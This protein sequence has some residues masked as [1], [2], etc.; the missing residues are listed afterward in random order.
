MKLSKKLFLSL[1]IGLPCIL[2]AILWAFVHIK[3]NQIELPQYNLIYAVKNYGP[4]KLTVTNNALYMTI[5]QQTVSHEVISPQ[6]FFYNVK[7]HKTTEIKYQKPNVDLKNR[8]QN[9]DIRVFSFKDYNINTNTLAPDGY[10]YTYGSSH[11]PLLLFNRYDYKIQLIKN[12]KKIDLIT[13]KEH[14][15]I[16]ILGWLIPENHH[17]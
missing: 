7:Y 10:R 9:K 1:G 16:K 3:Q 5:P 11:Q 12:T 8:P 17:D 2:V 14:R 15:P 13:P 4:M 6:I